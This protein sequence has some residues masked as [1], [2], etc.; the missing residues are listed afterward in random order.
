[1]ASLVTPLGREIPMQEVSEA[2]VN[3]AALVLKCIQLLHN[4]FISKARKS[5]H[6]PVII[7]DAD[8]IRR[9]MIHRV[10]MVVD[11]L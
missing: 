3:E 1:M 11:Q 5:F 8:E 4:K 7:K 10:Y 6:P 2:S 9:R